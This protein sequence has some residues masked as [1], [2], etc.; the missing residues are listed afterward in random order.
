MDTTSIAAS[1][2]VELL[3]EFGAQASAFGFRTW[4]VF[5]LIG[6]WIVAWGWRGASHPFIQIGGKK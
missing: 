4:H 1:P 2:A 5:V 3:R 6:L